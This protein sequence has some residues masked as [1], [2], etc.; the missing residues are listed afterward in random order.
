MTK[1]DCQLSALS[2]RNDNIGHIEHPN[3][4][5]SEIMLDLVVFWNFNYGYYQI[6]TSIAGYKSLS[7]S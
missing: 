3:T 7:R 4:V 5:S 1:D 6:Y 2:G